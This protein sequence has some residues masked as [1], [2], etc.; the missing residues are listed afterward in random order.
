MG[1][2]DHFPKRGHPVRS[3]MKQVTY[4]S[5]FFFG[6]VPVEKLVERRT[7]GGEK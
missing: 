5:P 1:I 3:S 4:S 6:S 7:G 2:G